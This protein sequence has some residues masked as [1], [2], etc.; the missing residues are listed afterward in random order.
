MLTIE[1]MR[2]CQEQ[3]SSEA[4]SNPLKP[5]TELAKSK[6]IEIVHSFSSNLPY[7]KKEVNSQYVI[8]LAHAEKK[9]PKVKEYGYV[10]LSEVKIPVVEGMIGNPMNFTKTV[11]EGLSLSNQLINETLKPLHD[12]ILSFIGNPSKLS[13]M[14]V[15]EFKKV[16]LYDGQITEYKAELKK[17]FNPAKNVQVRVFKEMYLNIDEFNR[18]LTFCKNSLY[19]EFV[20]VAEQRIKIVTTMR[21]IS[22]SLDLL[23][24]RIEQKPETFNI[25]SFNLNK[26]A[27]L[28]VSV[29]E[30]VE[31][32]GA[33]QVYADM[34][35]ALILH[36]WDKIEGV[37]ASSK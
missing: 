10:A 13:K 5:I 15:N 1:Q 28:V 7:K 24:L 9:M 35:L 21:D 19:P 23:M 8:K 37:I 11:Q 32:V 14:D 12:L 16:K 26:L 4:F 36:A 29:A 18:H 22:Q 30:V 27:G 25:N 2:T 17:E 33:M 31:F 6:F 34:Q 20:K 3:I